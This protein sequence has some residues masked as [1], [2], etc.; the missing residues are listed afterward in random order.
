VLW[1]AIHAYSNITKMTFEIVVLNFRNIQSFDDIGWRKLLLS[2]SFLQNN[3]KISPLQHHF[4]TSERQ[5]N[6]DLL[7]TGTSVLRVSQ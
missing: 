7:I 4:E 2:F 5:R 3:A 1:G 6:F